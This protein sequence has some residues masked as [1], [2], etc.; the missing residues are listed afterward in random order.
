M[1]V[2]ST[3]LLCM[4][5]GIGLSVVAFAVR[6]RAFLAREVAAVV[7]GIERRT[8][9]TTE[10]IASAEI[11]VASDL[12]ELLNEVVQV[13]NLKLAVVAVNE[14]GGRAGLKRSRAMLLSRGLPRIA[15]LSGGGGAFVIAALGNFSR[16]SLMV[17][18]AS[19][20][21]GLAFSFA[22]L[23]VNAATRRLAK[24]YVGIVDAL[25]REVERHAH[26]EE[27]RVQTSP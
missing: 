23:G 19:A 3:V 16:I 13:E 7:A 4:V 15:L 6:E 9:T 14:L 11:G 2:L 24:K 20:L 8:E 25:A 1:T 22:C 17:A 10:A 5:L 26:S 18:A 21:S 12:D 27:E